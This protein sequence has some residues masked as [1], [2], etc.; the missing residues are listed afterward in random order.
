[1]DTPSFTTT[2]E[3][4]TTA[5]QTTHG[6]TLFRELL[7]DTV[8]QS[9]LKLLAA[10]V[11][12]EPDVPG[13]ADAYSQ[14][15]R[16]LASLSTS[17]ESELYLE[18]AWQAY[19]LAAIIDHQNVLSEQ[20]ER[21][22]VAAVAQTLYMQGQRDLR[23]LQRLFQLDADLLLRAVLDAVLPSMPSLRDAWVPWRNL[24]SA[25]AENGSSARHLLAQ[26][27]I[28]SQDWAELIEPLVEHWTR[29]GTGLFAHYRI[30]RWQGTY[31]QGID[32]PDPVQLAEL[33]GYRREQ[34]LLTVNTERF[35]AG[36]PAH[37]VLLYGAPGTGKSSTV[38]ALV[39]TYAQ[40]GLR[41][42]EVHKEYIADLPRIV[43]QLRGHAPRFL[44]F[45]DDLS[46][47][48]HETQ[49]KV[50]KMLLEGTAE[51]RPANVL[52]YATTNRQNLVRENFSD[53]GKPTDDV[54]WRD[55]MDEKLSLMHRFGLRV[56]FPLPDQ[57][58]Y[59]AI[60]SGLARQRGLELPE[61]V[62][63]ARALQWERSHAGRSG[64]SARQFINEL[65]A[66]LRLK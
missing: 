51:A 24:T 58:G 12:P 59:L 17:G 3:R 38:K 63:H 13:I 42:V 26:R 5:L 23:I 60:V 4:I 61:D 20:V 25:N 27:F 1:M 37:D 6:L 33:I 55:T 46:F 43:A 35:L 28:S 22:G 14:T 19:L 36:L 30:L 2:Q 50:L 57:D 53:R 62:L 18:D 65:E 16:L 29:H 47:E 66:E 44:L 39:N 11:A 10:L 40:Q 56:T 9:V 15:F 45:V 54:H 41:L 34:A 7:D 21:A 52:L 31:L 64:R 49:Y 32:Y 48:E 8:T